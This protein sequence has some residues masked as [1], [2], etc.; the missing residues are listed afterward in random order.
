MPTDPK[1]LVFILGEKEISRLEYDIVGREL[2]SNE[3]ILVL[4][5]DQIKANKLIANLK[6]RGIFK[7]NLVLA[8]SPYDDDNYEDITNALYEFAVEKYMYFSQFCN[9]LGAKEVT[10]QRL[11]KITKSKIRS[12][13]LIAKL[14]T[15]QQELLVKDQDLSKLHSQI[16]VND[17]FLGGAPNLEEAANL[18]REKRLLGDTTM[19]SLLEIRKQTSNPIS[20]RQ[21]TIN[22]SNESKKIVDVVAKIRLPKFLSEIVANFNAVEKKS[23]EYT[24]TLEVK[25]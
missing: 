4:S 20:T 1:D 14:T 6:S 12:L 7:R 11:D 17:V 24:L 16:Q 9:L 19:L 25:F 21:L 2:L 15:G 3:D 18:L 13:E 8:K 22:L 5:V 23:A 10:V